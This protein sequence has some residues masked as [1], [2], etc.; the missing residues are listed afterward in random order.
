LYLLFRF[1]N[2]AGDNNKSSQHTVPATVSNTAKLHL[3]LTLTSTISLE[4]LNEVT[5]NFSIDL[6]IGQVSYA[7]AFLAVLKDGQK[8]AI[9]KL[10]HVEEIQVQVMH[11][12]LAFPPFSVIVVFLGPSYW[13]ERS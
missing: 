8:S 13:G 5:R 9:K 2:A 4:E 11:L 6:L 7:Q 12:C 3:T 1:F 10:D